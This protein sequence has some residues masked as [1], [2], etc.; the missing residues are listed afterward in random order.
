MDGLSI[1]MLEQGLLPWGPMASGQ[2]QGV[3]AT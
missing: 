3:L 1:I 2:P